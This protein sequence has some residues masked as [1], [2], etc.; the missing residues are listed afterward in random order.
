MLDPRVSNIARLG[1]DTFAVACSGIDEAE[2]EA[3]AH[4]LFAAI[5]AP[6]EVSRV[7]VSI[8]A[9]IG[10]AVAQRGSDAEHLL[11]NA[12]VALDAARQ[13]AGE[14]VRVHEPG[15]SARQARS[16]QIERGLAAALDSGQLYLA[17]QPQVD[18]QSL[19]PFGA[20]AL[21]RWNHPIFGLIPPGEFISIAE[22]SGFIE[23]LGRW[24]SI[25]LVRKP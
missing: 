23:T 25:A 4:D 14:G 15:T 21:L 10:V 22:G 12:E 9:R 1:G 16:R 7:S 13:T 19:R 11:G 20:E 17:Y 3:L 5:A 2:A 18:L 24:V 8:G 6:F